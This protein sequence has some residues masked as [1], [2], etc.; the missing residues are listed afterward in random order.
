M[1]LAANAAAP[2]ELLKK[3]DLCRQLKLSG[4]KFEEMLEAGELPQPIFLG[5]TLHSRR[6]YASAI[7]QH[8]AKLTTNARRSAPSLAHAS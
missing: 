3:A 2:A 7:R 5:A 8:L 1:K 6:W 4:P